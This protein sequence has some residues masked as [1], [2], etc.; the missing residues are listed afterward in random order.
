MQNSYLR[1]DTDIQMKYRNWG[2]LRVSRVC[3]CLLKTVLWGPEMA[4]WVK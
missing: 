3:I 2:C 1:R 4:Q